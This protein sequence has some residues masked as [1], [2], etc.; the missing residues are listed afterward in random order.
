MAWFDLDLAAADDFVV[1]M[2][3]IKVL[4]TFALSDLLAHRREAAG[5]NRLRAT[6][7]YLSQCHFTRE[8]FPLYAPGGCGV[9]GPWGSFVCSCND[10]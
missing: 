5:Y 3:S 2:Y 8:N 7:A 10:C 9:S 4:C 1:T 6:R